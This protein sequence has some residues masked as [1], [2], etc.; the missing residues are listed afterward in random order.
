MSD[1]LLFPDLPAEV[2]LF[3]EHEKHL[4]INMSH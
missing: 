4:L 1:I 2:L 3:I